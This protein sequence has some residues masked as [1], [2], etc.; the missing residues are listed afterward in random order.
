MNKKLLIIIFTLIF[1][2]I[3]ITTTSTDYWG[4]NTEIDKNEYPLDEYTIDQLPVSHKSPVEVKQFFEDSDLDH[5][6]VLKGQEIKEFDY[7]IKHSQYNF[8]GPYGYN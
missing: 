3:I 8:N 7:K 6:G 2:I 4:N 1:L 5:D